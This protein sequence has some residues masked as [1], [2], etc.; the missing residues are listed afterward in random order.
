MCGYSNIDIT[1]TLI[2]LAGS[3]CVSNPCVNQATCVDRKQGYL[4]LCSRGFDGQR[5][6][7]DIDDCSSGPCVR[8]ACKDEEAAFT[9]N[10]PTGWTG[11]RCEIG[12]YHTPDSPPISKSHLSCH[13]YGSLSGS[14]NRAWALWLGFAR[15]FCPLY[16]R[17]KN[18][19]S[20]R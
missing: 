8:G 13:F 1:I 11:P 14:I 3:A 20:S 4:C 12:M 5:C 19:W 2:K 18:S 17:A 10:C 6:G 16:A 15:D 9:C 7:R